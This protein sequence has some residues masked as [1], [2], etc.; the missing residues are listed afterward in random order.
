MVQNKTDKGD[1]LVNPRDFPFC[2]YSTPAL[3]VHPIACVGGHYSRDFDLPLPSSCLLHQLQSVPTAARDRLW[4]PQQDRL[5]TQQ[6][7]RG[8]S[9]ETVL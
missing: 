6:E 1:I 2:I 9:A 4:P 5:E 7:Y 8:M 3:Y